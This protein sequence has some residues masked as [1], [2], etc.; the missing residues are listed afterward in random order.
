MPTP[1]VRL[2]PLT[3]LPVAG[4]HLYV[5]VDSWA[6]RSYHLVAVVKVCRRRV[7][8]RWLDDSA[9]NRDTGREYSVPPDCLRVMVGTE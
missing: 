9:L 1:T 4:E 6:G 3:Y 7:R 5:G 8:V 2:E